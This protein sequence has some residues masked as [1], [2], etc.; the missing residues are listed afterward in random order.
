MKPD[1]RTVRQAV[2]TAGGFRPAERAL[3]AEGFEISE[4]TIRRL[5]ADLAEDN[6]RG[7]SV[8]PT[9]EVDVNDL[10]AKRAAVF[11]KKQAV[12]QFNKLV[13]VQVHLDGPIGLGLMGD[14]HIDSDGCNIEL[15]MKHCEIFDGR[16]EGLFAG[17]L[18]DMWNNW[19]G[20]L[21]RLWSEQTTDGAEARALVEHFLNR[22]YWMFAIYGNHDLWSGHSNILEP[23]L[24]NQ[25]GVVR[26]WRLR[27][28][29]KFPN[30]KT[31]KIYAAHGFPGKSMY[32]QNMGAVKKAVFDGQHDIY[33]SGHTHVAGYSFGTH[34]G[35][36][37]TWHAVQVG[38]YKEIDS[39]GDQ[40]GA[41]DYNAY[42][43]PV[44]L[45][46]P[47]ARSPLN[48]IR[49]EFDPEQAADRLSW[50]RKRWSV[51]KS[52]E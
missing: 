15:L 23:M 34:P 37:K 33:V 29:L 40:I 51:N 13:P 49:W 30:G 22:V 26:D 2:D 19:G 14:P 20:R 1:L 4:R 18:G 11:A 41:E 9:P 50:M 45:I 17:L 10:I 31:C 46:D 5:L 48:F 44:A 38:T 39:F 12:K 27:L 8:E 21:A 36:D 6:G 47:E 3:R 24:K 16:N 43:C 32:L 28:G 42:T 52:C 25:A 35:S 7:F